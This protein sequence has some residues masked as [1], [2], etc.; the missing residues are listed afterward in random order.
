MKFSKLDA[1]LSFQ[2]IKEC[3]R[4]II[5]PSLLLII[6]F[7][8]LNS[9]A[10]A[11]HSRPAPLSAM[12]PYADFV[13][14]GEALETSRTLF[15]YHTSKIKVITV[16][17]GAPSTTMVVKY[18]ETWLQSQENVP[19]L[20]NGTKYFFFVRKKDDKLWLMGPGPK[21]FPIEENG[22]VLCGDE[23]IQLNNC[24]ERGRKIAASDSNDKK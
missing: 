24:V 5:F 18:G 1:R 2:K 15:G 7:I 21:Y 17:K 22:E 3:F 23:K 9:V 16:V 13:F 19:I 14:V 20:K 10:N 11:T 8:F 6:F 12:M 4:W